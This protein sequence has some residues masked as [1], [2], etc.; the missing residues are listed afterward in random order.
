MF[1]YLDIF[2]TTYLDNLL[3]YFK[4]KKNYVIYIKT[5]FKRMEFTDLQADFKTCEFNVK[6]TKYL[7]SIIFIE[8]IERNPEKIKIIKSW[9]YLIFR[10]DV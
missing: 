3:I 6:P 10:K 4:N 9:I 1:N 8:K 7:G 5:I 2:Y